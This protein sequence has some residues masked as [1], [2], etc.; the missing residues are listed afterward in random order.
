M[1]SSNV[2]SWRLSILMFV[3]VFTVGTVFTSTAPVA[4]ED[5]SLSD[6]HR[7]ALASGAYYNPATGLYVYDLEVAINNGA[8]EAQA[9]NVKEFLESL[10]Q[11]E[12][13]QFNELIGFDPSA[14]QGEGEYSIAIPPVIIAIASFIG[15]AAASK[16]LDEVANYGIKK[17]CQNLQGN[18]SLFDDYCQTNGHV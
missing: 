1:Q 9:K 8:P 14:Y 4:A 18:W 15:G 7:E 2:V 5:Q 13:S 11:E 16:L 17:A 12:V 10:S 3:V 6:E